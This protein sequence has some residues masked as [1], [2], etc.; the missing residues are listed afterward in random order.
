MKK[1][2]AAVAFLF[3]LPFLIFSQ[4]RPRFRLHPFVVEGIGGE[5]A[6][7]IE[8]FFLSYLGDIGFIVS[9]EEPDF[10]TGDHGL[11]L[12]QTPLYTMT[13]RLR[14]NEYSRF[15]DLDITDERSGERYSFSYSFKNSNELILKA[16]SSLSRAFSADHKALESIVRE[17]IRA[18]QVWGTWKSDGSIQM[19]RLERN[20][21]GMILFSSGAVMRLRHTIE[22]DTLVVVQDSPNNERFYH[23]LPRNV[24]RELAEKA[25]PMRWEL[26]LSDRGMVLRGIVVFTEAVYDENTLTGVNRE[27]TDAVEWQR[28]R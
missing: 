8:A 12:S 25:D 21:T 7:N 20:G 2:G 1:P 16:H 15:L 4:E 22:D 26:L 19:I 5:E 14:Q 11:S 9:Q 17:R 3:F 10:E 23:P 28:N 24:A 18:E 6:K 13:G 27:T